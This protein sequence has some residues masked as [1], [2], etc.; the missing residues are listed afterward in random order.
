MFTPG[1]V[2]QYFSYP[3]LWPLQPSAEA[4]ALA[5]FHYTGQSDAVKC[6]SCDLPLNG[7][8]P[9]DDPMQEHERWSPEC[10]FLQVVHQGQERTR[11]PRTAIAPPASIQSASPKTPPQASTPPAIIPPTSPLP[12]Y[13]S[14]SSAPPTY[15]PKTYKTIEDLYTRHAPPGH[16]LSQTHYSPTSTHN[17]G[18]LHTVQRQAS[19]CQGPKGA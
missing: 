19:N 2:K 6:L 9:H 14:V 18:S 8:E 4:M 17:E 15:K 12:S 3:A 10:P 5:G 11:Q 13:R 16:N 7:W 1:S